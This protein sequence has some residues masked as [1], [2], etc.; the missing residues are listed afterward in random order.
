ML[1]KDEFLTVESFLELNAG[2]KIQITEENDMEAFFTEA[3]SSGSFPFSYYVYLL[4]TGDNAE[5][6][7]SGKRG[8]F[9]L[10]VKASLAGL[11]S[12]DEINP[13]DVG[14]F[15]VLVKLNAIQADITQNQ[16]APDVSEGVKGS[17]WH[18]TTSG[19]VFE[20]DGAT[21]YIAT[22]GGDDYTI[23]NGVGVVSTN[24]NNKFAG[25]T[26]TPKDKIYLRRTFLA[27]SVK[28][29]LYEI[30]EKI[31]DESIRLTS[32]DFSLSHSTTSLGVETL[33]LS[34]YIQ[35]QQTYHR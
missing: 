6:Q 5:E 28:E 8:T 14:N 26:F 29:G 20:H 23:I 18:D 12:S 3:W 13:E 24:G 17:R 30:A 33:G 15:N 27:T 1:D 2:K 34:R 11:T 35:C 21:V 25:Y 7:F 19:I 9:R 16:P 4:E 32:A 31:S 22:L 10:R